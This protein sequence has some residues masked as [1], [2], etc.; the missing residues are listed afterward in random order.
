MALGRPPKPTAILELVGAFKKDPARAKN[1]AEEPKPDKKLTARPPAHLPESIAA[2]WREIVRKLPPGVA[3][4][5]DSVALEQFARDLAD[6]RRRG[7]ALD[8]KEGAM[9][10]RHY[11]AFGMTPADR[12]RIRVA[13]A[14]AKAKAKPGGEFEKPGAAKAA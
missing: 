4:E 8:P 14:A 11:A 5:S 3:F 10:Y 12:T 7:W 9:M 2:C 13:P 1:R 6:A